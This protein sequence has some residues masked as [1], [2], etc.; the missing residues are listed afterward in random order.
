MKRATESEGRSAQ[1][2]QEVTVEIRYLGPLPS[3]EAPNKI[4]EKKPAGPR[5]GRPG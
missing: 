4:E 3:R 2:G 1:T 5:S